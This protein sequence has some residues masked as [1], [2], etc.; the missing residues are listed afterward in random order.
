MIIR[1]A[2]TIVGFGTPTGT[3]NCLASN[4]AAAAPNQSRTTS[5]LLAACQRMMGT[6]ELM[7]L[8]PVVLANDAGVL[9]ARRRLAK[10][11]REEKAGRGDTMG[12]GADA[13]EA[14]LELSVGAG[15]LV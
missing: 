4:H 10:L 11:F 9:R 8:H 1:V 14:V 15:E 12:Q 5:P 2:S 3:L 6:T 7:S 13:E